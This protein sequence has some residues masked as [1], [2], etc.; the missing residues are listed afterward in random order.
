VG[1]K[2]LER[3]LTDLYCTLGISSRTELAR[4][5]GA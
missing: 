4:L 1:E 5:F 3:R 2:T